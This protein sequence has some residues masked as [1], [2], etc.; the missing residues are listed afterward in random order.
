MQDYIRESIKNIVETVNDKIYLP[1]IQRNF[2]WKPIQVYTLFDSLL[3][4]YPIST[5]LF[6]KLNGN[7][8][9]KEEIKKLK[10]V[11]QSNAVNETDTSIN[12]EKEYLLVLDGQQ[13][14]TTFYLVLKGNYIIRNKKY[15]LYFNILSGVE[16]DEDDGL[17]YEFCFF[18]SNKGESFV[19]KDK[20]GIIEKA[21]YRVKNIYSIK[22][23]EDVSDV[24]NTNFENK[25]SINVTKEQK[26]AVSKLLRM[27]RY[28]SIIYYY[29]ETEENY[30]KV[31]D[32]FVRTNAG[33]TKLSYSD[34]LFS[35]IKS[36]WMEAREKFKEL[37]TNL[38]D[39]ERF[40]FS[41]DFVLKTILF[42][43]AKDIKGLKYKTKNFNIDLIE[44][45]K[46]DTYWKKLTST[47]YLARDILRDKFHL[48]H[49]KLISSNNALIPI[50]YWLFKHNKKAIGSENN[51]VS[52]EDIL[53]MRT[54]F[55]KALLSGVF[56]GQSDTILIKCKNTID[57]NY[58]Y[59]P[60]QEI[61]TTIKKE[62]KKLMEITADNVD[63]ISYN[64]NNSYLVLSLVYKHSINFQPSLKANIPEQDHIFSQDE[65]KQNGITDE[66]IN[67][68]YN[69]RYV[70]K[71]PNQSKSNK[72]Y[73]DWIKTQNQID[74]EMHLIPLTKNWTLAE[75]DDFI[76]ERRTLILESIG[77]LGKKQSP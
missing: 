68:I 31:L 74:K 24:I 45:I 28:E 36:K 34:L 55:V 50:I 62:T 58:L 33:G 17:L 75:Y 70:G 47:I 22:D 65:L 76:N 13:R 73:A 71:A 64:S 72:P 46:D 25:Y 39:N 63:K 35:T 9:E 18:N 57:G 1:D 77:Y 59:F 44:T 42:I 14:I 51:C 19:E 3:R 38:N 5:F 29:P 7:Y 6:W 66:R 69:I 48:T 15:D 30:D 20:S 11:S 8:L 12:T 53:K 41:N 52:E 49:K 67:T 54:W 16:K 37:N 32:I 27:L 23:I 2:V 21:W 43:N 40:D 61:E 60:A 56:G 26:K 4:D 10:F